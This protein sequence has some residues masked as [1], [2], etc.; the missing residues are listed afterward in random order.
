LADP[1]RTFLRLR[2]GF[3]RTTR[4]K[5]RWRCRCGRPRRDSPRR[6]PGPLIETPLRKSAIAV[7]AVARS[8]RSKRAT[9]RSTVAAKATAAAPRH[10]FTP[11]LTGDRLAGPAPRVSATEAGLGPRVPARRAEAPVTNLTVE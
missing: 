9:L 8:L 1:G 5:L 11:V 3:Q 6:S 10:R 2:H 4:P 7:L